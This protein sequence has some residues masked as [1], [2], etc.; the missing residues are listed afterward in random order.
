VL[1]GR[2]NALRHRGEAYSGTDQSLPAPVPSLDLLPHLLARMRAVG[3]PLRVTG[4]DQLDGVPAGVGLATYRIVQESLTNVMRHAGTAPTTLSFSR[5]DTTLHLKVVN[6]PGERCRTTRWPAVDQDPQG[7]NGVAGMRERA[8]SQ[9]GQLSAGPTT[10][11]GFMVS[12][13]L[14]CPASLPRLDQRDDEPASAGT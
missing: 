10:E 5:T 12:A 13:Q 4:Q 2:D 7:G 14:P 3:L 9:G 6:R 1:H 8:R 11:N